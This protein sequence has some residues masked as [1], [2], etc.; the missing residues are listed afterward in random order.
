MSLTIKKNLLVVL[1]EWEYC[2]HW[3]ASRVKQSLKDD[4]QKV[5]VD[6]HN[7]YKILVKHGYRLYTN[8]PKL[9]SYLISGGIQFNSLQWSQF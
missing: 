2:L 6:Y 8:K 3:I 4:F 1:K 5:L 9:I 7:I